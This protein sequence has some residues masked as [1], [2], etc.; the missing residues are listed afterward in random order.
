MAYL[1]GD[2]AKPGA[3]VE[4]IARGASTAAA[5]VSRPIYRNGSVKSPKP[6]RA[7]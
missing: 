6:R 3:R 5:L 2:A 1:S 7:E 4:V